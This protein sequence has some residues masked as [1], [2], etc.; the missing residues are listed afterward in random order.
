MSREFG[1]PIRSRKDSPPLKLRSRM[2]QDPK[3]APVAK[4]GKWLGDIPI[5]FQV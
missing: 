1:I 5:A 3:R 4:R 2:F